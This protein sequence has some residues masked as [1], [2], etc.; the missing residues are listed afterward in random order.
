MGGAVGGGESSGGKGISSGGGAVSVCGPTFDTKVK[1][2]IPGPM[3]IIDNLANRYYEDTAELL[4]DLSTCLN[5]EVRNLVANSPQN[6]NIG[7]LKTTTVVGA[8][9]PLY[10]G[11]P[12]YI[13]IDEPL[14]A[15][16]V[17]DCLNFGIKSIEKCFA[18]VPG[19]QETGGAYRVVHMCCG[20]PDKLN[21]TDYPKADRNAYLRI[22]S[23]IDDC[24]CIDI[25]SLEDAHC[26]NELAL[27]EKFKKTIVMLGV[28]KVS[29]TA[30]ESVEHIKNRIN[31]VLTVLPPERLMIAPDCGLGMLPQD[32]AM[33]KLKN[34]VQAV[35]EIN[36]TLCGDFPGL[37][38]QE[39]IETIG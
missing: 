27:F 9:T 26:H 39:T 20:Y 15:R 14:W 4:D 38:A 16:K 2:T 11:G 25:I 17:D 18:G 37:A 1:I 34:M 28:V 30:V 21:E 6:L 13:Q 31:E 3:T 23:A 5:Y 7:D 33:E 12:Q 8:G 22:A 32:I 24:P 10:A 29:Y 36:M 35:K 19:P